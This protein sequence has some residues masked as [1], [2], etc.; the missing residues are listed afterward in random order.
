MKDIEG[1]L[2]DTLKVHEYDVFGLRPLDQTERSVEIFN[3]L[4]ETIC[5]LSVLCNKGKALDSSTIQHGGGMAMSPTS[6]YG[7]GV[8][9]EAAGRVGAYL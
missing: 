6:S 9:P 1:M 3:D 5:G 8:A 2:V 4:Y 7:Y